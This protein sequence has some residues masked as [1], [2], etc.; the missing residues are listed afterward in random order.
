MPQLALLYAL[1]EGWTAEV[2]LPTKMPKG[3]GYPTAYKID[4]A[5]IEK[6]IAIEVDGESHNCIARR[7]QDARKSTFLVERG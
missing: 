2:V 3:S 6:K 4:I 1:G 7:E 5:N